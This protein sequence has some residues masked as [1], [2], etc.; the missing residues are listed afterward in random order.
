MN[1]SIITDKKPQLI[2]VQVLKDGVSFYVEKDA[3]KSFDSAEFFTPLKT[4]CQDTGM[5]L[6]DFIGLFEKH[7]DIYIAEKFLIS[8]NVKVT[9]K[10]YD[11]YKFSEDEIFG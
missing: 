10:I 8:E 5:N 2:F 11:G 3:V 4:I 9:I 6:L 7:G 1:K